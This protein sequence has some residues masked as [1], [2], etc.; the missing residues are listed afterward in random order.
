MTPEPTDSTPAP[1]DSESLDAF[2]R[3]IVYDGLTEAEVEE[4]ARLDEM[5][6]KYGRLPHEI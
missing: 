4:M 1:V 3:S 5:K 2:L 6:Q